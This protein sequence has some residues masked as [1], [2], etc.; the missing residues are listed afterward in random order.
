MPQDP[1]A[2]IS[3]GIDGRQYVR[4]NVYIDVLGMPTITEAVRAASEML[5]RGIIHAMST[6]PEDE[7]QAKQARAE[8]QKAAS[9]QPQ[10]NTNA[11]DRDPVSVYSDAIAK[12]PRKPVSV[13]PSDKEKDAEGSPVLIVKEKMVADK[14]PAAVKA[15][16]S[17][18]KAGPSILAKRARP[19]STTVGG[20]ERVFQPVLKR[21]KREELEKKQ[22]LLHAAA[23]ARSSTRVRQ[24]TNPHSNANALA[25]AKRVA[26]IQGPEKEPSVSNGTHNPASSSSTYDGDQQKEGPETNAEGLMKSI[27]KTKKTAENQGA[28]IPKPTSAT[29]LLLPQ[30]ATTKSISSLRSTGVS[31]LPASWGQVSSIVTKSAGGR[32][33]TQSKSSILRKPSSLSSTSASK[34][35]GLSSGKGTSNKFT[36]EQL[37]MLRNRTEGLPSARSRTQSSISSKSGIPRS[38]TTGLQVQYVPG[39]QDINGVRPNGYTVSLEG[40]VKPVVTFCSKPK[41]PHK[42]R[43]NAAERMFA[44]LQSEKNQPEA[45]ALA[46]A[47]RTE[48]ELYAESPGRV[49]YR[50]SLTTKLRE[51]RSRK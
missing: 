50:S 6:S 10:A 31:K 16:S 33:L 46:E 15:W 18:K 40:E 42:L 12:R 17:S 23:Q 43:Q 41:L 4:N 34:S 22:A 32:T 29:K 8:R 7:A 14:A 28:S 9:Q 37:T 36:L 1:R 26:P 25:S 11:A 44:V 13:D 2:R 39:S 24:T 47:L 30:K 19:Q 20:T 45:D 5:R 35:S 51:L 3:V 49:E 27:T 38:S 21:E 48:Q